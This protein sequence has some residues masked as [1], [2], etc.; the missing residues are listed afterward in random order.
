MPIPTEIIPSAEPADLSPRRVSAEF[1]RLLA[2]GARLR[3]AGSAK[4]NPKILLEKGYVP[5]Y[6]FDLFDTRF[7]LTDVRQNPSIRFFVTY[8]V[9]STKSGKT[10]IYPRIFY[11]DV[12]LVWRSASHYVKSEYEFWIGKGDCAVEV[13]NGEET[14][15]TAEE[16]SD[17]PLE[18]QTALETLVRRAKKVRRDDVAVE[19]VL[20]R[21]LNDRIEPFADFSE[22]RRRA[23]SDPANLINGGREIARFTRTNDPSSLKFVKGFEPDFQGGILETGSL[24]SRLYGGVLKR[25]RILSKNRKIQYLFFAG[26]E[27]VWIIP[28]QATTTEISS[29][30]V[31]TIDV[32]AAEELCVPGFEYHYIDDTEDPPELVT[33]IPPGFAGEPSE[34]DESRSDASAWLNKLPV[35]KKFRRAVLRK[36][37]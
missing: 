14:L 11:K 8:V 20:R 9:K 15:T 13:V 25:Y 30:G 17:L 22:P 23:Q 35:I 4:R 29:Y 6:R 16:T 2:D 34:V 18:M 31:R 21:G 7:Y 10:D 37:R 26:P 32:P 3:P 19:L 5:K 36:G 24:T 33:Q 1:R 12:S 28:P 27:H